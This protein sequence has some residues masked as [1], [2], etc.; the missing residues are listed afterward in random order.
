MTAHPAHANAALWSPHLQP[1]ERLL[2]SATASTDMRKA[3][4]NRRRM[5]HGLAG[6]VSLVIGLMLLVRFVESLIIVT[7]QPSM[8]AAFTPLYVVFALAMLALSLWGFRRM[9]AKPPAA[10]HYAAT[11]SRLIAL[12]AAGALI[13]EMPATDIDSVIASGRRATPDVYVLR[14]DDPHEDHVFPIEHIDR[15]LEAKAIIEETF[16]PAPEEATP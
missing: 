13:T 1:G 14:K 5:V 10:Q 16:L 2:W 11:Q 12:D 3:D 9:T 7:A 4:V 8:L 6:V 15:P